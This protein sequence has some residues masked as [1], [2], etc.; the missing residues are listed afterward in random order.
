MKQTL[1]VDLQS[2][3]VHELVRDLVAD[4]RKNSK[5]MPRV[6]SCSHVFARV[7]RCNNLLIPR[8]RSSPRQ[9]AACGIPSI[10]KSTLSSVCSSFTTG[11]SVLV[12]R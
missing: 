1:R 9:T 12:P 2:A 7:P 3:R 10:L 8:V 4:V 6:R 5:I 11:L